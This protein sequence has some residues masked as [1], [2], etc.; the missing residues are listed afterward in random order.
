MP[1][2]KRVLRDEDD[3]RASSSTAT[4]KKP[5]ADQGKKKSSLLASATIS[6]AFTLESV[7]SRARAV[8]ESISKE[9][10]NDNVFAAAKV[11][12]LTSDR[13]SWVYHVPRWFL[14]V[15]PHLSQSQSDGPDPRLSYGEWLD[16]LWRLHPEVPGTIKMFGRDV[17]TPRFQQAYGM[18]YHFSGNSYLSKPLPDLIQHCVDTMQAMVVDPATTHKTLLT[19]IIVNWYA[20]GEHYIGPH[21][22]DQPIVYPHSPVFSLSL[23]ATRKFVFTAKSGNSRGA[24]APNEMTKRL[25]LVLE[26]GDLVVMGGT[27]QQSHKHALPKMKKCTEKRICITLRCVIPPR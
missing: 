17:L 3:A 16:Q 9:I 6:S 4:K 18:S 15:Y 24:S 8:T 10:D 25:E 21:S 22:D 12:Y 2:R 5:A 23:G 19:A 7:T 11:H 13:A 27:T 1:Q 26:D 14:Q 20:N